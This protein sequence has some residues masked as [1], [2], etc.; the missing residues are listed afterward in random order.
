MWLPRSNYSE[1]KML[2]P[3]KSAHTDKQ[4][5]VVASRRVLRAG[6]LKR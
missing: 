3:N 1:S 4:H 5:Q 6:G 2:R